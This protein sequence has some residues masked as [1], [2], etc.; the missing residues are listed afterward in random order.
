[1]AGKIILKKLLYTILIVI[2]VLAAGGYA[3]YRLVLYTPPLI[4]EEDRAA[5]DLMPLPSKLEL[6]GDEINADKLSITGANTEMISAAAKR[7]FAFTGTSES[8]DALPMIIEYDSAVDLPFMGM[9]ESYD[10]IISKSD[11]RLSAPTSIGIV[12]G[13]E[14]LKQLIIK[15]EGEAFL[16]TVEISDHP[17]FPWRGL[18]IDVCRH[19]IPKEVILRNLDAMS[20]MKMNVL[21]L[22]LSEDQGFRVESKRYPKLHEVGSNGHYYT[23]DDIRE[24]IAYASERGIRIVPEF[25]MPGHSKSWQIAYPSLS[26]SDDS[27]QFGSGKGALFGPPLDPT[28]DE[29]YEFLTGL[30]AEMSALFPDMY[31]HIGGDEVNPDYWEN[32]ERI[33]AFMAEN[34]IS[35]AHELQTYFNR[36]IH[37]IVSDQGKIMVGWDEISSPELSTDI[38]VQSW[39]SHKSLFMAVQNGGSG[40]LSAG[41]YMDHVL[42]AGKHYEVD[43]LILPGAVDI[44]PDTAFWKMYDQQMEIGGNIIESQLVIFDRDPDN[45]F[46]FFAMMSDRMA[47]KGAT[48][49]DNVLSCSMMGPV[50]ELDYEAALTGDSL[51]GNISFGLLSFESSGIRSGGSDMAGTELPEIEVI[52]PLTAEEQQRILGGEACQW[53]E[54]ADA[55]NIESRIW[56]R[57]A[58]IAEKLWSPVSLTADIDDMYRR[59]E[60]VNEDLVTLGVHHDQN[61]YQRLKKLVSTESYPSLLMLMDAME[62]VKYHGRMPSLL[63]AD[64]IYLPDFELNHLVDIVRPESPQARKFN[65]QVNS[66]ITE[67]SDSNKMHITRQLD[68]WVKA[69]ENIMPLMPE[70]EVLSEGAGLFTNLSEVSTEIRNRLVSGSVA[71]PDSML[72]EKITWLEAG[73]NGL[74]VAVAPGLRQL[75]DHLKN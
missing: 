71:L 63:E 59:L 60:T 41:L 73:E 16:P 52:R 30:I 61:Y 17:R 13:F 23:Q 56:P 45:V 25:D 21:H 28:R 9:N 69:A 70:S 55:E 36:R 67:P 68:N 22:H 53:S 72:S 37:K 50:G 46:G 18:M 43:P 26:S 33:M 40:I 4:S 66:Y 6:A 62:E 20:A 2:V 10:L 57:T 3:Y 27:L 65:N 14:T 47:F 32:N 49:K 39:T 12:R 74:I 44:E 75:S 5:I 58:A 64:F 19:W 38:V 42:P 54:F 31:F 24:I 15:R 29:V 34:S 1:M 48:I 51:R 11:I 7:Y 35:D 8:K